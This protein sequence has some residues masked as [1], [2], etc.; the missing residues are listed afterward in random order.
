VRTI[1]EGF[2]VWSTVATEYRTSPPNPSTAFR[3][4]HGPVLG[5]ATKHRHSWLENQGSV[6]LRFT[7][8][9]IGEALC[10]I[11]NPGSPLL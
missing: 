1:S 10:T 7:E 5:T 9:G 4:Q 2:K 3:H 8:E 6:A 11:A